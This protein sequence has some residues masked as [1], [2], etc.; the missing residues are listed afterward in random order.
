MYDYLS[1]QKFKQEYVFFADLDFYLKINLFNNFKVD[2]KSIKI[3]KKKI[4]CITYFFI[5]FNLKII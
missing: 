4:L 3:N 5:Y 2:L 1:Q